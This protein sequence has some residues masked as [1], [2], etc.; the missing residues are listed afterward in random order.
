MSSSKQQ[1]PGPAAVQISEPQWRDA[2][3]VAVFAI[4][5][6]KIGLNLGQAWPESVVLP[7]GERLRRSQGQEKRMFYIGVTVCLIVEGK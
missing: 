5:A 1:Q 6:S 3:P 2:I 4:D 7:N